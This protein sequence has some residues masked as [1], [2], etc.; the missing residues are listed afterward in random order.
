MRTGADGVGEG[1]GH[2]VGADGESVEESPGEG[3]YDHPR[4]EARNSGL[5]RVHHEGGAASE[6]AG[7]DDVGQGP[8]RHA[9]AAHI[10]DKI[11]Q[12]GTPIEPGGACQF[13]S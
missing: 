12:S 13:L 1:V 6:A 3:P 10:V 11:F 4:V 8:S 9:P 7:H 5:R 2:V